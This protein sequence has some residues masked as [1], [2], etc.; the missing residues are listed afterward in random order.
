[1]EK[2]TQLLNVIE[3]ER[4]IS[5]QAFDIVIERWLQLQYFESHRKYHTFEHIAKGL[6]LL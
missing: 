4:P 3:P 1:M 2:F 5:G 6:E